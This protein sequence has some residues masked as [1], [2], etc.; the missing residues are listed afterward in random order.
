MSRWTGKGIP[1]EFAYIILKKLSHFPPEFP[2][3]GAGEGKSL[4][5]RQLGD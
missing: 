3:I 1:L 2:C 5:Q 4:S